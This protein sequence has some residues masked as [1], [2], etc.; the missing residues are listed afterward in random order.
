MFFVRPLSLKSRELRR[1]DAV[2]DHI[3]EIVDMG[4]QLRLVQDAE[5]LDDT[6]SS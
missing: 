2:M 5:L 3:F 1:Q 6:A 4:S